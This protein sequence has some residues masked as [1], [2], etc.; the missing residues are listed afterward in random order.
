M[1]TFKN[2]A[3]AL[4]NEDALAC[5]RHLNLHEIVPACPLAAHTA[6]NG[7]ADPAELEA[8]GAM[9]EAVQAL[10]PLVAV[11]LAHALD[12]LRSFKSEAALRQCVSFRPFTDAR[13]MRLSPNALEQLEVRRSLHTSITPIHSTGLIDQGCK[14]SHKRPCHARP[15]LMTRFPC[16]RY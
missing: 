2:L 4:W 11:A 7:S 16:F 12:Y 13:S 5:G 14:G 10:P 1:E 15:L 9:A 8:A 6:A 3:K